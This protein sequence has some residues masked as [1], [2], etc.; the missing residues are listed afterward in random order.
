MMATYFNDH[1]PNEHRPSRTTTHLVPDKMAHGQSLIY[2][3]VDSNT[4]DDNYAV[5]SL[6]ADDLL[7]ELDYSP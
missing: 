2:S 4:L 6:D 3:N 1:G 7:V 5:S